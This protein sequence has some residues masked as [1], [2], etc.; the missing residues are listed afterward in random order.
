MGD[1]CG[2]TS[3][4]IMFGKARSF[5]WVSELNSMKIKA[6]EMRDE[7]LEMRVYEEEGL[8]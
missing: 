2:N 6:L 7:R 3:F 1:G 5:V 4:E 8:E